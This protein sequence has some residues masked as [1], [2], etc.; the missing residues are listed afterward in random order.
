MALC[1][2]A[3]IWTAFWVVA[4]RC[5]LTPNDAAGVRTHIENN[6]FEFERHGAT[7]RIRCA[8]PLKSAPVYPSVEALSETWYLNRAPL[9]LCA[10]QCVRQQAQKTVCESRFNFSKTNHVKMINFHSMMVKLN[11]RITCV[12][13]RGDWSVQIIYDPLQP[14]QTTVY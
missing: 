7:R 8:T 10:L 5:G 13:N 6:V 1:G 12:P 9:S 14:L 3:G 2:A 4:G 11:P